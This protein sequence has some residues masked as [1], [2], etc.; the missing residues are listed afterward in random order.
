MLGVFAVCLP[1][2]APGMGAVGR[3]CE[4]SR[5]PSPSHPSLPTAPLLAVMEAKTAAV[6]LCRRF[7]LD[8]PSKGAHTSTEV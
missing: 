8:N 2:M 3:D 6:G 5:T 4:R 1:G 7:P